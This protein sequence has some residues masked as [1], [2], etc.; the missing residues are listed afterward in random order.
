M[1]KTR[2]EHYFERDATGSGS[3]GHIHDWENIVVGWKKGAE[4]PE[5]VAASAHDG[6][7]TKAWS[8]IQQRK[9][10]YTSYHNS[11][12]LGK[13][14]LT[15]FMY[16]Q[17]IHTPRSFTTKTEVAP[18]PSGSPR[19]TA[20]TNRLRITGPNGSEEASWTTMGTR[21][22]MSARSSLITGLRVRLALRFRMLRLRSTLT[23]L[24][25]VIG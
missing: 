24:S 14:L 4:V 13:T 21:P 22:K 16:N 20:A 5:F 19:R 17:R 9:R 3:G 15:C 8:D 2:Y 25:M 10:T 23:R 11:T 6:Y 7:S 12:T 1:D 18:M